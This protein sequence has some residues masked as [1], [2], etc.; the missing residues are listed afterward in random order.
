MARRQKYKLIKISTELVLD[1]ADLVERLRAFQQEFDMHQHGCFG[2]T[3]E[4]KA[5]I[6][7]SLICCE[8]DLLP[9][10]FAQLAEKFHGN[11]ARALTAWQ[12]RI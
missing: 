6:L 5:E 2:L 8:L 12:T 11:D 10:K 9:D 3:L 1:Y 4:Q 7:C